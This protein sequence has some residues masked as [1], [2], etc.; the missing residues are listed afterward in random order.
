MKWL[1]AILA[2]SL[3]GCALPSRSPTYD[4]AFWRSLAETLE[5]QERT[6]P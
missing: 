3:V 6:K 1:A 4:A 5:Q 2:A